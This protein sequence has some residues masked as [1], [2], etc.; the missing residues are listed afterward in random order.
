MS[1]YTNSDDPDE[2][3]HNEVF[4]QGL[5]C[6]LRQNDIQEKIYVEIITCDL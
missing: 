2:M 3:Q 1:T 5:H 4:H 6:L